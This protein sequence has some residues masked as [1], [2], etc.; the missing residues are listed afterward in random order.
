[1]VHRSTASFST[2]NEL[3]LL[4]LGLLLLTSGVVLQLRATTLSGG[5]MVGLYVLTLPMFLRTPQWLEKLEG[6]ALWMIFG[7]GAVFLVG[8][9]LSVYRDRLLALPEKIRRREGI[10]RLLSWR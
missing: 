7:G 4:V 3:G 5:L 6:A 2:F 9:L 8:L 1:V 10:F